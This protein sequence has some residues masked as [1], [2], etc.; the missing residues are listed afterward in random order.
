[1]LNIK[2]TELIAKQELDFR[3]SIKVITLTDL[4][5]LVKLVI[6]LIKTDLNEQ[7]VEFISEFLVD[8]LK[9]STEKI[10]SKYKETVLK[11]IEDKIKTSDS[12][13]LVTELNEYLID[14]LKSIKWC[15]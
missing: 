14:T 3:N 1:M 12:N 10:N 11:G 7:Q 15:S 6:N 5:P 4:E 13:F 8:L 2:E 9:N